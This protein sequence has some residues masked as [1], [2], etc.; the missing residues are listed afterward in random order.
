MVRVVSGRV[1]VCEVVVELVVV[2]V[3]VIIEVVE[4]SEVV[5]GGAFVV[6]VVVGLVV[7]SEV[8]VVV[9]VVVSEDEVVVV[10][11][12]VDET[13][14]I[15]GAELLDWVEFMAAEDEPDVGSGVVVS[16]TPAGEDADADMG[17]D[18][19]RTRKEKRYR[20][21]QE[22][23]WCGAGSAENSSGSMAAAGFFCLRHASTGWP[24]RH[25][26]LLM[27]PPAS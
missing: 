7:V 16:T 18:K 5:V 17:R 23:L 3:V 24:L 8:V 26:F 14:V 15:R 25:P 13:G 27:H 1:V 22:L 9:V 10:V 4:M 12:S 6:V 20:K 11:V 2:L 21:G 19:K